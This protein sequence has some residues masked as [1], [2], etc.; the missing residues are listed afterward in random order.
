MLIYIYDFVN[1]TIDLHIVKFNKKTE[2]YDLKQKKLS[3][4]LM[5]KLQ[6]IL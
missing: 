2:I 1:N 4:H 5:A 3:I 6:S